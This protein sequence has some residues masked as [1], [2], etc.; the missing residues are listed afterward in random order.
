[1]PSTR[2][3]VLLGT[4]SALAAL[5]GCNESTSD[6]P[7]STVTPVDVPRTKAEA[8]QEA[9]AIEWPEIPPAVPVTD[10]RLDPAMAHAEALLSDLRAVAEDNPDMD[11]SGL[12]RRIPN[13]PNDIVQ[14]AASELQS[15][16][17]ADRARAALER[18]ESTIREVSLPLGYMEAKIGILNRTAIKT[19]V[20][21]ERKALDAL[22][23]RF[24]YRIADPIGDHLPP[25]YEAERQLT[26]LRHLDHA[27]E[28][29]T[30]AADGEI[31]AYTAFALARQNVE[32]NRRRREAID[33]LH[34]SATDLD[35]PS[36]RAAIPLVLADLR[37][38]VEAIADAYADRDPP[39]DATTKGRI[40]NI[41]IHIGRRSRRWLSELDENDGEPS[42]R[43]LVDVVTWLTEFGALDAAIARTLDRFENGEIP[44]ESVIEAKRDAVG[45]ME[46]AAAGTPL[47]R[48]LAQRS[49]TI[50]E[51][52]DR[53]AAS[54]DD[55]RAVARTHLF[56]SGAAE[57]TRLSVDRGADLAATLQAQQS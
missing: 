33:I 42:A 41:R 38:E 3:S 27:R 29:L 1:M 55:Q 7:Q 5:A 37:E 30:A 11:L 21:D 45:G 39:N 22:T 24:S 2:R 16:R 53:I 35:A 49:E 23:D 15:A 25:L 4:A 17:E 8:M 56:Y 47:Q 54:E 14:R 28:Q 32:I 31:D 10:A 36:F 12:R 46:T 20:D 26:D 57:W 50:L 9:A 13:D 34:E 40:R 6:G 19:M 52:A 44:A 18:A 48:H 51:T 43:L